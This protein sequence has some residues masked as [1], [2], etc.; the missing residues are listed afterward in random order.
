MIL[1]M[2]PKGSTHLNYNLVLG[3]LMNVSVAAIS[4]LKRSEKEQNYYLIDL[5]LSTTMPL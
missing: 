5:A 1:S 2:Q 3:G 4:F